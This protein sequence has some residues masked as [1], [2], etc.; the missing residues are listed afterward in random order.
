MYANRNL[1]RGAFE[2]GDRGTVLFR[3]NINFFNSVP[4]EA[5]IR[6][7]SEYV[8]HEVQRYAEGLLYVTIAKENPKKEVYRAE[9]K[10]LH[11]FATGLRPSK[12]IPNKNLSDIPMMIPEDLDNYLPWAK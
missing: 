11:D 3:D 1:S 6:Q 12:R 4:C 8:L 9:R 5:V 10:K 2:I 7:I